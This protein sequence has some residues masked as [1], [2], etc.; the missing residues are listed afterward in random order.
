MR[1]L[2][3]VVMILLALG[4]TAGAQTH[5]V[6]I[7]TDFTSAGSVGLMA[8]SEPWTV[9]ADLAAVHPDATGRWHEGLVYIVNRAGADNVE[10]LD[11][12]DQL[13][14][15]RQFSLGLG[16]NLQDIAFRADGTA[17]VS[18]YDTA[19][20]LHVD[21]QTGAIL[22]VIST[23]AFAD[24]DG[25]PET[26]RLHLR[27]ER[28]FVTCERLDRD[29]WYAP[30]GD[31]YLLVLDT[32]GGDWVDCDATLPGVQGILLAAP[33]PYTE[34][35]ADGG[36]LLVGC[37]G[38][39]GVLDGGVDAID[40]VA[41][42][43]L[44]LEVTESELAG[45]VVELAGGPDG[46]RHVIV[47][48]TSFVTSV[49]AYR[50]G[51]GIQTVTTGTAYDHAHLA[52]DGDALLFVA[53]R[54]LGAAGVRV[55]DAASGTELTTAPIGTGLPPARIV[56]PA[57]AAVPVADLP[58][59]SLSLAPPWPN[60]AN[61]LTRLAFRAPA[62]AAVT[63]RLVDLRGRLLRREALRA[64]GEGRGT[65]VFDGRDRHGRPVASGTYRCVIEGDGGFAARSLT[66]VR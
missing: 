5:G 42:V 16:R 17:Y 8:M 43:S 64:D 29:S 23:A 60:P 4:A 61:P 28:L 37:N 20:L 55:F 52:W 21:P 41:L 39:Y 22:D 49:Q 30:V 58:P 33:N 51:G 38:Y 66:I 65:W 14:V 57:P 31:S 11:P 62:D 59:A 32:V 12:A 24:A 15:V 34:I 54:A 18:C 26:G 50:V 53:D 19:E 44:G 27:G 25:L 13:A 48:S 45:D 63:L 56:L 35:V 7:T 36:L 9:T 40:P 3:P 10:V 47:S 1:H 2:R 6:V 46:R